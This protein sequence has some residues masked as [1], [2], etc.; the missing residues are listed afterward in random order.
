M[1]KHVYYIVFDYLSD[2][3]NR[4]GG[5]EIECHE[6]ISHISHIHSLG[7]LAAQHLKLSKP[8]ET[9]SGVV[10]TDWKWLRDESALIAASDR[11]LGG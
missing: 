6:A 2:G 1:M 9:I 4:R 3:R 7:N 5:C 8:R 10:I 11:S